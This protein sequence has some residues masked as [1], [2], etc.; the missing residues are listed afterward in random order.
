MVYTELSGAQHQWLIR[1]VITE[2][3][4]ESGLVLD[5]SLEMGV[6]LA[7]LADEVFI[8]RDTGLKKKKNI[9]YCQ[10]QLTSK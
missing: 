10:G 9:N 7:C 8:V 4:Q 2:S 6:Q 3:S 1:E 5:N